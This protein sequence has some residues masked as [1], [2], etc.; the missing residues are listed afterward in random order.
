MQQ[1]SKIDAQLLAKIIKHTSTLLSGADEV[2]G[3]IMAATSDTSVMH[4]RLYLQPVVP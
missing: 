2:S 1:K 4:R 3:V